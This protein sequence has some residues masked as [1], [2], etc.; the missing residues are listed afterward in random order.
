MTNFFGEVK[1]QNTFELGGGDFEPIPNNTQLKSV[2]DEAKWDSYN[3]ESYI[4]L[5]WSV[6]EGEFKGR[7]IYQKIRVLDV[8]PQ[9]SG[10][11]KAMLAAID[12]NAGGA[13]MAAGVQPDDMALS[14]NLMNKPMM[15]QVAIWEINEKKGN[16]IKAVAPMGGATAPVPQQQA[17]QQS[18]SFDADI[19]F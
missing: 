9:K 18:P 6:L 10:N 11:A 7:K 16:W 5:R 2:I 19:G 4:S 17:P 12:T 1:A 8:S 14:I 13:L 3:E 15:I